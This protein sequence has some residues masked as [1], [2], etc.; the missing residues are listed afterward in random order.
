SLHQRVCCREVPAL[1]QTSLHQ[2]RGID[3]MFHCRFRRSRIREIASPLSHSG[4]NGP[5][6][7]VRPR[8]R[9]T[10]PFRRSMTAIWAVP[11][12]IS[13]VTLVRPE[14]PIASRTGLGS[15]IRT[16]SSTVTVV[17]ILSR[18]PFGNHLAKKDKTRSSRILNRRELGDL[19]PIRAAIQRPG[20]R[21]VFTRRA[22]NRATSL[23]RESSQIVILIPQSRE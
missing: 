3:E 7:T 21:I 15:T 23:S 17:F 10:G 12:T 8:R 14:I 9:V 4:G 13:I 6:K 5:A 2:D 19:L 20:N 16:T 1:S 18:L 11:E 22:G